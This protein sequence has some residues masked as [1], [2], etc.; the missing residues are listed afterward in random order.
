MQLFS[1]CTSPCNPWVVNPEKHYHLEMLLGAKSVGTEEA[2]RSL[3]SLGN[4]KDI[5][6]VQMAI[7][8]AVDCLLIIVQHP[9]LDYCSLFSSS[10]IF[11]YN[12]R[13]H[14]E[15]CLQDSVKRELGNGI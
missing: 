12:E 5:L 11:A 6:C 1:M 7:T 10:E 4:I 9:Y 3:D 15:S 2:E 13:A 14:K 8:A